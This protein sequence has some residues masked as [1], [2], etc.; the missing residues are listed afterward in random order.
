MSELQVKF[1]NHSRD[2]I[3]INPIAGRT[4]AIKLLAGKTLKRDAKV[5]TIEAMP[6]FGMPKELHRPKL[7]WIEKPSDTTWLDC[8]ADCDFA[9]YRTVSFHDGNV[10]RVQKRRFWKP[11]ELKWPTVEFY[12]ESQKYRTHM[13]QLDT[14]T[15][16]YSGIPGRR[17]VPPCSK[18]APF[19][20]WIFDEAENTSRIFDP[21]TNKAMSTFTIGSGH[22][23]NPRTG[24]ELE[25]VEEIT[26]RDKQER[27]A[28][29]I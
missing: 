7:N 16:L 3:L 19:K 29:V 4:F 10:V 14:M 20:R 21:I 11:P 27:L 15:T 13:F 8:P 2:H 1:V 28:Q 25:K 23:E 12:F 9:P 5:G 18:Y 24:E 6:G 26:A 17:V 22:G